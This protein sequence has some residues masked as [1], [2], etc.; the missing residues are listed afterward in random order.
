VEVA[1]RLAAGGD[2]ARAGG[3]EGDLEAPGRLEPGLLGQQVERADAPDVRDGV[4]GGDVARGEQ[5]VTPPRG[6]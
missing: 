3:E 6:G 1:E 2:Q 4:E 5:G